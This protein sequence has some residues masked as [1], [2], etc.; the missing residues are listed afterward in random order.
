MATKPT[1]KPRKGTAKKPVVA[2]RAYLS[3]DLRRQTLLEVAA[4][5]VETDGWAGLNMSA[6]A[7]RGGTSRQLIYQHFPS[8]EKLLADTAWHIFMEVAKGTTDSVAANP[9]NLTE[10][11]K[12]AEAFSLD[13]P[14]GRGDALWQLIAGTAGSTPELEEI[15]QGIRKLISGIWTPVV[16]KA[17]DMNE[18]DARAYA[19]MSILAFWGMRQ[20]VRDGELSR[21]RG[22]KL[23]NGFME[24]VVKS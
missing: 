7:E 9:G 14:V 16:R 11:I 10:A 8:M 5:I 13:L 17:L 24:R 3:K 4:Q 20:L 19:W 22:V 18:A 1:A 12:A 23:F 2:K 6:L 21:T 15:R